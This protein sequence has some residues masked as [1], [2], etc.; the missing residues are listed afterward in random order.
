[1]GVRDKFLEKIAQSEVHEVSTWR[2][3]L[4]IYDETFAEWVGIGKEKKGNYSC[5]KCTDCKG[6]FPYR[7]PHCPNCGVRMKL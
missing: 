4:K 1:M 6:M 3:A 7:T 2:E 5:W